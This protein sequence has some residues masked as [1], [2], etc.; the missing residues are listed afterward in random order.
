MHR[1]RFDARCHGRWRRII[2]DVG[3]HEHTYLWSQAFAHSQF[4]APSQSCSRVCATQRRTDIP[5]NWFPRFLSLSIYLLH[6]STTQIFRRCVANASNERERS[7]RTN[8]TQTHELQR[9]S[10]ACVRERALFMGEGGGLNIF[11]SWW[12]MNGGNRQSW[13]LK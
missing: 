7:K 11:V 9:S 8:R 10:L 6:S 3:C 2:K 5:R 13:Q 4:R 1:A 12:W